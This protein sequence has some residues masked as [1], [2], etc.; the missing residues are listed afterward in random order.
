[1][2]IKRIQLY[3][4][5]TPIIR[6]NL[7]TANYN[8]ASQS[9]SHSSYFLPTDTFQSSS[10][11]SFT[12]R[13]NLFQNMMQRYLRTKSLQNSVTHSKRPYLSIEEDLKDI[14]TPVQIKVSKTE[15]INA[16]DI[17]KNNSKRYILFLHGFSQNITSN[18][19]LYRALKD[20]NFGILAIDYRS[21]GRNRK[22]NKSSEKYLLQDLKAS[23]KYLNSKGITQI[24]LLGHS[25]G[26]YL[27][28][29]LSKSVPVDFQILVS[30]MLSL[31][32]WL[33]NVIK[34]PT[35]YKK[36]NKMINYIPGFKN[37]YKKIFDINKQITNN[38]TPTYV[39]Q[40]FKD[41]YI[42][43]SKVNEFVKNLSNLKCYRIITNGGHRMDDAKISAISDILKNL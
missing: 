24:G 32:F 40:A 16:L 1:M 5:A 38:N 33:K 30:P 26:G 19:P 14:T 21:Y 25:F 11:P 18:Q 36:E 39:I 6:S 43:T 42:R 3:S 17:N 29:K 10:Q 9:Y 37:Q 7:H 12:G 15:V 20:S 28:T 27:A 2:E 13:L 23:I 8:F 4:Q 34:H 35:K 31:E 22:S 41:K